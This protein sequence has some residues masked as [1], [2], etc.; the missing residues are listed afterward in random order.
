M[1]PPLPPFSLI[2]S[3]CACVQCVH[4]RV[5]SHTSIFASNMTS[6]SLCSQV[7]SVSAFEYVFFLF[8]SFNLQLNTLMKQRFMNIEHVCN[9]KMLRRRRVN[10][11]ENFIWKSYYSKRINGFFLFIYFWSYDLLFTQFFFRWHT[12]SQMYTLYWIML[13]YIYVCTKMLIIASIH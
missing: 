12:H 5:Y 7:N 2:C 3:L 8:I 9:I 11:G 6:M 13:L 4:M 1:T 10:V